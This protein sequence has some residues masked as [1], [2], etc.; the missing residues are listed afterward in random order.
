MR[1][2]SSKKIKLLISIL[3]LIA[4]MSFILYNIVFFNSGIEVSVENATSNNLNGFKLS[5]TL[6]EDSIEF[7]S[8]QKKSI[9]KVTFKP[10]GNFNRTNLKLIYMDSSGKERTI[11]LLK[12]F[13]KDTSCKIAIKA[14]PE[15]KDDFYIDFKTLFLSSK[16]WKDVD[17]LDHPHLIFLYSKFN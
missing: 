9:E 12:D 10:T 4:I 8:I 6:G 5:Y 3:G 14:I 16:N 11:Y 2:H 1:K 15:N 13:K 7:P 17:V